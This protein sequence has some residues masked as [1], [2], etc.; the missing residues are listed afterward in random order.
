MPGGI[1]R[2]PFSQ[3]GRSVAPGFFTARIL[4]TRPAHRDA[5]MATQGDLAPCVTTTL[6]RRQQ[7]FH[8]DV[9]KWKHFPLYWPFVRGIHRS[10]V[11][12]LYQQMNQWHRALMFS[13]ICPWTSDRT[14]NRDAGDLRRHRTH[15]DVNVMQY[16]S[17]AW[18]TK[19]GG[20]CTHPYHHH[21]NIERHTAHTIVSWPNPKQRLIVVTTNIM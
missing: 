19:L 15:Y 16:A 12:S 14:N 1:T 3:L 10:L 5:W 8:D 9:I 6:V 18:T 4:S 21:K 7:V 11:N 20:K 2:P 13:L 17:E